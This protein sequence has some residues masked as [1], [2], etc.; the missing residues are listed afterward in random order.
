TIVAMVPATSVVSV[1]LP[2][3]KELEGMEELEE[4]IGDIVTEGLNPDLTLGGIVPC[5]VPAATA[6]LA[7]A[8]ALRFLDE[9]YGDL[10]T[11]PVP[12]SVRVGA[13]YAARTSVQEYA[14]GEPIA[15]AYGAV[16]THLTKA[17]VL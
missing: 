13:A 10:V 8:D 9:K 7:Y 3:V 17:G 14:A 12:R 16:L 11:P 15:D 4:L 1:T 5:A 6:G 2:G